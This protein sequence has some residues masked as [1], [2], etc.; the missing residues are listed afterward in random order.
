MSSTVPI[1]DELMTAL[2]AP[3]PE[4]DQELIALGVPADITTFIGA[5]KIRPSGSFYQ[6]DADGIEVAIVPCL[7]GEIVTDLLAFALT[8]PAKWWLRRCEAVFVGGDTL[9]DAVMGEPVR[10]F[11]TPLARLR[12]GA[13][14]NGL[15]VLDHDI[16][17]RELAYHDII[18]EDIEHG[19]ELDRQ[20]TIPSRRPQIRVPR[21][22]AA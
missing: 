11:R 16:A 18:A 3:T 14:P 7:D 4:Q 13:P 2:A 15:V 19:L 1:V 12:A 17:R 5:A 22:K 20:L 9:G 8:D 21:E 10:V 6:P